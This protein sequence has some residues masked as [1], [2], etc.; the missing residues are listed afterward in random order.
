MTVKKDF[1]IDLESKVLDLDTSQGKK[2]NEAIS[3][4]NGKDPKDKKAEKQQ[5]PEENAVEKPAE[6]VRNHGGNLEK[7]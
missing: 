5:K 4:L 7:A 2:I 1:V 6:A 3:K